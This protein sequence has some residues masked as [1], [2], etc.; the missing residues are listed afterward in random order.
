MDPNQRA[1][2]VR[3]A[4]AEHADNPTS[5]HLRRRCFE[6]GMDRTECSAVVAALVVVDHWDGNPTTRD[7]TCI[8]ATALWCDTAILIPDN[9]KVEAMERA[10]AIITDALIR[11]A[12]EWS[13]SHGLEAAINREV[14]RSWPKADSNPPAG[15]S[16]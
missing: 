14:L 4:W 6:L 7:R 5:K 10:I 12:N 8:E 11:R 13:A 2:D 15:T 1:R 16:N 3:R 9:R